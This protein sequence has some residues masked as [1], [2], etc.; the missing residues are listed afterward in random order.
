MRC[1]V[2]FPMPVTGMLSQVYKC[3]YSPIILPTRGVPAGRSGMGEGA[4]PAGGTGRQSRTRAA[5][6]TPPGTTMSPRRE[7]ADGDRP[8]RL[9]DASPTARQGSHRKRGPAQNGVRNP[10]SRRDG[11]PDGASLFAKRLPPKGGNQDVAPPGAPSPSVCPEGEDGRT[12]S[13]G[14]KQQ[15]C[16]RLA[17]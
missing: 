2:E 13:P 12:A 4:A 1:P 6:G 9:E 11:A 15:G 16:F 5:P 7:P 8:G 10:V 17:V 14:R 3:G